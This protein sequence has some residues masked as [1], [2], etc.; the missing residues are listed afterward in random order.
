MLRVFCAPF[1][2]CY[3]GV[4]LAG[5]TCS[6]GRIRFGLWT[7]VIFD[8][9][10]SS[11][12]LDFGLEEHM[13]ICAVVAHAHLIGLVLFVFWGVSTWLDLT[14]PHAATGIHPAPCPHSAPWGL[15]HV[16]Q[17]FIPCTMHLSSCS[18][19]NNEHERKRQK[20]PPDIVP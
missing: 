12:Q 18:G 5:L 3:L 2:M 8:F 20:R 19:L 7:S 14:R 10:S 9:P 11:A 1:S 16:Y 13:P 17:G 6:Q 4:N 15:I